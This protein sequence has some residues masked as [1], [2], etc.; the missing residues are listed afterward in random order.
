MTIRE[1]K[2]KC[3]YCG[4][5]NR[6]RDV[7][8]TACGAAREKDVTFFLEDDAPEVTDEERLRVA[9]GGAE[10][11]CETCGASNENSRDTCEQCGAPR[12]GSARRAERFIP[13]APPP[14]PPPPRAPRSRSR[15]AIP[16]L[17]GAGIVVL[18]VLAALFYAFRTHESSLVVTDV[19]WSRSVEVEELRTL[20]EQGWEDELP[21]DARVVSKRR[22]LHHT[23][24]VQVG[25]RAVE[26]SY[27]ERVQVGTKKVKVG[28]KDL[29]NGYFE[30]VYEDEP[31]YENQTRTRTVQ[32]PIYEDRPVYKN[33][34][35][36]Q[37]DR[38]QKSRVAAAQ[39]RDLTPAWP[40]LDET[41]KLRSGKRESRYV[42]HLSDPATG[43]T[44]TREVGESEFSRYEVG[45][46]VRGKINNLGSLVEVIP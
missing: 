13:V 16:L 46:I 44:F 1:G 4:A 33:R 18:V 5:V 9:R 36:Y 7:E 14:P 23:D 25:S 31:I 32:K 22:E 26:E 43:K 10:W 40:L 30:D 19:E 45:S 41:P 12:G 39:G 34:V 28:T 2:W 15:L 8:C 20:T 27:T 42:V 29:G 24:K 11:I 3:T 38:W 37:V 17:A 6:G 35:T 21:K